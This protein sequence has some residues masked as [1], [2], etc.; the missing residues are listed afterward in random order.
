MAR[1]E[2]NKESGFV[3]FELD[4]TRV[5]LVPVVVSPRWWS[6]VRSSSTLIL[7]AAILRSKTE[8]VVS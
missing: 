1:D 8:M 4:V 2:E 6:S 7:D 3:W 5:G